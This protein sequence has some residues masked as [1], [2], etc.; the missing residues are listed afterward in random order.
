MGTRKKNEQSYKYTALLKYSREL[1]I[2]KRPQKLLELILR[3]MRD[4]TNSDGGT[5]YF[6][7]PENTLKF[8][9]VT[10]TGLGIQMGGTYKSPVSFKDLP[11][12]E[13]ENSPNYKN[14]SC[15]CALLRKTIVLED[16]YKTDNFNFTGTKSFDLRTGYRTKSVLT[17]PL[18]DL[19]N[20]VIGVTQLINAKNKKNETI[21][22]TEQDIQLAEIL[23]SHA[24]VTLSN[25]NLYKKL[26]NLF[27]QFAEVLATAI[28]NKSA[29][30]GKHCTMVH[31]LAMM[32]TKIADR[33]TA[34]EFSNFHLDSN[35]YKEM[36]LATLLHDCGKVS[37]PSHIMDKCTKLET[38]FDRIEI[39]R[40]KFEVLKR[41]AEIDLLKKKLAVAD[42]KLKTSITKLDKDFEKHINSLQKD[43]LFLQKSNIGKEFMSE[44]DQQRVKKIAK[45]QWFSPDGIRENI[46]N[47][48]EI[49]NLTV[50]K[51]T[52]TNAERRL[53]NQHSDITLKMLQQLEFPEHLSKIPEIAASHHEKINGKGH[54]RGLKG[55]EI[56]IQARILCI[57]DIFEA[58]TAKDRPYKKGKTLSESLFIMGKMVEGG[59]L[60]HFIFR[61]FIEEKIYLKYA[62]EHLDEYQRDEVNLESL[63]GYKKEEVAIKKVA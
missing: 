2:E 3:A 58:L 26:E 19:E 25:Q 46:L 50:P 13:A 11:L 51:G 21:S 5:I 16:A 52:L 62:M 17:I 9:V 49:E 31:K 22:Y 15:C 54:P 60:D 7:T 39:V 32:I 28:D 8:A 35:G 43:L 56:S 14:I 10:N 1:A 47:V 41:D 34:P 55:G 44:I 40:S 45:R 59:E 4:I 42:G 20:N 27:S 18:I 29:Y 53:I 38:I 24:A 12:Y 37:T 48:D 23:A 6:K 63:P 57:A 36:K 30:T 61:L 33:S